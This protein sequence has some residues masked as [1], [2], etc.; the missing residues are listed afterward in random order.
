MIPNVQMK[1]FC[2]ATFDVTRRERARVKW[3]MLI[4]RLNKK[5]KGKKK[6][7]Q[8]KFFHPDWIEC[9]FLD[10]GRLNEFG[11]KFVSQAGIVWRMHRRTCWRCWKSFFSSLRTSNGRLS[12]TFQP[13]HEAKFV[14]VWRIVVVS[15]FVRR[16][17]CTSVVLLRNNRW[18]NFRNNA[19]HTIGIG[20]TLNPS[21]EI[22]RSFFISSLLNS[23][24]LAS[25]ASRSLASMIST[26]KTKI[27]GWNSREAKRKE[28]FLQ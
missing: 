4:D 25:L 9:R 26:F 21:I 10:V 3:T 20:E 7:W 18:A 27:G 17:S 15:F 16:G 14:F 12:K 2:F 23:L 22:F 24:P 6:N 13:L 1:C 8:T 11:W 19:Q 28:Q 5:T